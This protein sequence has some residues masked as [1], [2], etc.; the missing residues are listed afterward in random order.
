MHG[1]A[2][3]QKLVQCK[4]AKYMIARVQLKDDQCK[5]LAVP[6]EPDENR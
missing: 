5:L 6:N 2:A 3:I 1:T 4:Y